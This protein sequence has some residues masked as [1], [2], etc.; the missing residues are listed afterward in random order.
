MSR[1]WKWFLCIMILPFFACQSEYDKLVKSELA[2]GIIH[3]DLMFGL[4]IG[5]SKKE[6]FE[7]CWDLNKNKVISQGPKNE[8]VKYELKPNDIPNETENVEMLFY[9]IFDEEQ[10]MIGLRKRFSY[11]GWSLWNE[12]FHSDKLAPKLKDYYLKIYGGNAFIEIDEGI[13]EV[14]TFVKVDGNR[15]ILIYPADNKDVVVKIEDNRY[16]MNR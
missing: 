5:Q 15:Q 16:K 1:I 11:L 10:K 13:E 3:D 6:F 4:K 9:G 12:D 2:T 7:I 14:Q 8:Y